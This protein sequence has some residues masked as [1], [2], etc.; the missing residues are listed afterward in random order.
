TASSSGVAAPPPTR[1]RQDREP[2]RPIHRCARAGQWSSALVRAASTVLY[3]CSPVASSL[4]DRFREV[5]VKTVETEC[6][7]GEVLYLSQLVLHRTE[8]RHAVALTTRIRFASLPDQEWPYRLRASV[9]V[10]VATHVVAL[11]FGRQNRG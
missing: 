6:L 7:A 2:R 11:A 9:R 3:V 5:T 8:R 10:D 1:Y 4:L